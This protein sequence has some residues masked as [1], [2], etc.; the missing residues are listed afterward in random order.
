M[1]I[2]TRYVANGIGPQGEDRW[3]RNKHK[4]RRRSD[5]G[6]P[7]QHDYQN[8]NEVTHLIQV[9]LDLGILVNAAARSPDW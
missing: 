9:F 7:L 1:N 6:Y 3:L 8:R 2:R 4:L 5:G